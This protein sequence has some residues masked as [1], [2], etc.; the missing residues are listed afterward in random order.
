MVSSSIDANTNTTEFS[1]NEHGFLTLKM[2]AGTNIW[3][4]GYNDVGWKLS[5]TDPLGPLNE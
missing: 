4:Y 5:E 2:D 3:M 1:Y